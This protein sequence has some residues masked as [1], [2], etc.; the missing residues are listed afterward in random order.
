M[1]A[2]TA[3]LTCLALALSDG[4]RNVV[5]QNVSDTENSRLT[6]RPFVKKKER[7]ASDIF[8]W[9]ACETASQYGGKYTDLM[10]TIL[11]EIGQPP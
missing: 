2:T 9:Q 7:R 3:N 8:H 6:H 11:S 5:A 10:V 4:K 1:E